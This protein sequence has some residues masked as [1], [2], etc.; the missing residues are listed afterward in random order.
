MSQKI[1]SHTDAVRN[2][3]VHG[4]LSKDLPEIAAALADTDAGCICNILQTDLSCIFLMDIFQTGTDSLIPD[5]LTGTVVSL[6]CIKVFVKMFK[7]GEP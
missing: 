2:K 3:V 5:V 6:V 4:R 7:Q 1:F